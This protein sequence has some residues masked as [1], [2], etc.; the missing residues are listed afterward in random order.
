M[1]RPTSIGHRP[2]AKWSFDRNVTTCFEDMLRRGIPQLDSTRDLVHSLAVER[3]R[4]GSWIVDLGCSRGV[5]LERLC[6]ALGVANR[7]DLSKPTP[8][9][10]KGEQ[11]QIPWNSGEGSVDG[12]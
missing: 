1:E 4:R 3:D 12:G 11:V 5:Q 10:E 9:G 6:Q 2:S 8:G 7:S